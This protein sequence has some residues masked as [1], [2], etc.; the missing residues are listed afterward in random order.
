MDLNFPWLSI[1]HQHRN[2]GG[3]CWLHKYGA[4]NLKRVDKLHRR[5]KK[6]NQT[7]EMWAVYLAACCLT[8]W[9][10]NKAF[11]IVLLPG[12]PQT[13]SHTRLIKSSIENVFVERK[14]IF[15]AE[16]HFCRQFRDP[17]FSQRRLHSLQPRLFLCLLAY[18]WVN[19]FP[20]GLFFSWC[21]ARLWWI[22]YNTVSWQSKRNPGHMSKQH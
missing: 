14:K 11:I 5:V 4:H 12:T 18:K 19:L 22:F 13:N 10:Y 2:Q 17:L 15:R 7:T 20:T 3:M 6:K 9:L 8:L 21:L 16:K 1:I